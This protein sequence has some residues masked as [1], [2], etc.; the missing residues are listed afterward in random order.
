MMTVDFYGPRLKV[1]RAEQHIGELEDIFAQYVRDNVK[2]L[3]GETVPTFPKYIP[4]VL[5]DALHNLR[6]A[7]DHAYHIVAEAN[8]AVSSDRRQFP[9]GKHRQRLEDFIKKWKQQQIT[10]SDKVI[11]AILDEIEPYE[12][13]KL[14][15]YGLHRLDITDKHTVLIPTVSTLHIEQLD[16]VDPTGA[17]HT[18]AIQGI[19]IVGDQSKGLEFIGVDGGGHTELQGDPKHAFAICFQKGHPFEA[20]SILATVRSLKTSTVKALDILEEAA[21]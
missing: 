6:A 15:L 8:C 16:Y 7:L 10:P 17:K 4:T 21:G 5:G 12:G 19:T 1:E 20:D 9:F 3:R 11:A 2:R 18:G 13:G 14:G